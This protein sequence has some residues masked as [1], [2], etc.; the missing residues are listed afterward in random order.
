MTGPESKASR[1]PLGAH[2]GERYRIVQSPLSGSPDS[3]N[4]QSR[5]KRTL[6]PRPLPIGGRVIIARNTSPLAAAATRPLE[7]GNVA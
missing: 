2:E 4:W 1:R 7:P 6:R 5:R 3:D